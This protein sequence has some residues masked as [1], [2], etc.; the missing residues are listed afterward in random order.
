MTMALPSDPAVRAPG[1]APAPPAEETAPPG[2]PAALLDAV[3][4]EELPAR[5]PPASPRVEPM[6]VADCIEARAPSRGGRVLVRWTDALGATRER[7]LPA[8]HGLAVRATD[9]VLVQQPGNWP[10]PIVIGV[11]DGHAAR[12]D[13]PHTAAASLT[14][15]SDEA[16]RVTTEDGAPLLELRGSDQ[17]PIVRLLREDVRVEAPGKLELRAQSLA[18]HASNGPVTISASDE[19]TVQGEVIRLN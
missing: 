8:L 7:W 15:R 11:V 13:L 16:I 1:G 19:V 12:P 18:L 14:L 10:E 6:L 9:R 17:G 5:P 3:V 4:A 2:E